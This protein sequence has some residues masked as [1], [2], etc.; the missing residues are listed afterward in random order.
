MRKD[1][2]YRPITAQSVGRGRSRLLVKVAEFHVI[3]RT[4]SPFF[5][6]RTFQSL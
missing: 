2:I 5:F 1:A 4:F 6:L 3:E